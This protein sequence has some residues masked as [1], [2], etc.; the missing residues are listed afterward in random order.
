[1]ILQHKATLQ[2]FK[3]VGYSG[4]CVK[5]LNLSTNKVEGFLKSS[6][7]RFFNEINE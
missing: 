7:K 5:L 4:Q 3:F 1:M 2:K 6:Y